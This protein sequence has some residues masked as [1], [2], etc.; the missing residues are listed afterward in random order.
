MK[1]IR[2]KPTTYRGIR[3]RSKSEA[4]FAVALDIEGVK[5]EYEPKLDKLHG[6]KPDFGVSFPIV[7]DATFNC[8]VEY[9]P[10]AVSDEYMASFNKNGAKALDLY[11]EYAACILFCVTWYPE[12][13]FVWAQVRRRQ[14]EDKGVIYDLARKYIIE[15][16][17]SLENAGNYRFDLEDGE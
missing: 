5:Y 11:S 17:D 1:T 3:Y 16:M 8:L 9:K 4:R 10:S 14:H 2:A 6:W 13:K 15:L 7:V 12:Y